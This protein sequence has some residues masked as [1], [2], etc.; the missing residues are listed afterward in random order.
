MAILIRID[1]TSH[2]PPDYG[3]TNFQPREDTG[4]F[5]TVFRFPF[6]ET[7]IYHRW[8]LLLLVIA[9][10][11]TSLAFPVIRFMNSIFVCAWWLNCLVLFCSLLL[12]QRDSCRAHA[13][14]GQ[15]VY[16]ERIAGS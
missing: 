12:I 5:I 9:P 8:F 4:F 6:M 1:N 10:G 13:T 15:N 14:D 3:F 7:I 16:V 2:T 11:G